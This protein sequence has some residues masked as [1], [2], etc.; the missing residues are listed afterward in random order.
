MPESSRL[1]RGVTRRVGPHVA[2]VWRGEARDMVFVVGCPRSGTSVFGRVLSQHPHMLYMHEP[3]YIWRGINPSLNV[4]RGHATRGQL[5]WDENDL[6]EAERRTLASWLHLAQTLG[7]RRRLVEKTPLNV[8]RIRWL[9]A[10]FPQAKFIHV[11]RHARDVALSMQVAVARWFSA[12]RGYE[13]DYW[14]ASWHYTIFE[15]YAQAVPE[16]A[17]SLLAVRAADDNYARCLFVWL[18]SVW[19]GCQAGCDTG[20]ERYSELRYE[21]LVLEPEAEVRRVLGFLE[22]PVDDGAMAQAL[23]MLHSD[24][25]RKPDPQPEVTAA[26]AGPLLAQLGYEV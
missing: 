15:E 23:A 25:V 13:D 7:G 18:C 3:R 21:S 14:Q 11:I 9:A 10:M 8:F 26:I 2:P 12:E 4:W 6:D 22:E 17:D 16:L 19:A 1:H 24:S 5:H 20:T